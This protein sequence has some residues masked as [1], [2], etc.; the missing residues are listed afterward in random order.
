MI[1]YSIITLLDQLVWFSLCS[2]AM[3]NAHWSSREL[4]TRSVPQA[5]CPCSVSLAVK[6]GRS[7]AAVTPES[8]PLMQVLGQRCSP[9]CS[10]NLLCAHAE[11]VGGVWTHD[12]CLW[13][14]QGH[15]W[16]SALALTHPKNVEIVECEVHCWNT[17]VFEAGS[18]SVD[19]LAWNS[20]EHN[21]LYLAIIGFKGV[22]HHVWL[23]T[24]F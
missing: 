20:Q 11:A 2:S 12:C 7:W 19:R 9:Q 21:Y 15:F 14:P 8:H 3:A 10:E 18:S 5:G 1:V 23:L 13:S 6:A 24:G 22:C 4:G 16:T 17:L